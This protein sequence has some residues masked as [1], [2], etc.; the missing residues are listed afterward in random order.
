MVSFAWV[1]VAA[2]GYL[3]TSVAIQLVYNATVGK[4]APIG[5]SHLFVILPSA[6]GAY[7][8]ANRYA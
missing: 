5:P 1:A 6:Y 4:T 8:I 7:L 2:G 3:A